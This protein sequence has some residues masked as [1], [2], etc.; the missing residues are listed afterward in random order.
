L[1][2]RIN[3]IQKAAINRRKKVLSKK[4]IF[5]KESGNFIV[6]NKRQLK[7]QQHCPANSLKMIKF[8]FA[9]GKR[10]E[11]KKPQ[12][13]AKKE[14]SKSLKDGFFFVSRAYPGVVDKL[15]KLGRILLW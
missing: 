7:S 14:N 10:L 1:N 8:A 15:G 2:S 9:I 6:K 5:R 13:A 3:N 11:K 4:Q 12:S